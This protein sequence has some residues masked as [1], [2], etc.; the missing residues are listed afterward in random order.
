MSVQVTRAVL[1]EF[2]TGAETNVL[3]LT[4]G[5][6]TGKT[7]AWREALIA[8]RKEIKFKNYCYISL[9]GINTMAELRMALFTKS[10]AVATL[11]ENIDFATIK[12]HWGSMTKDWMK[13]QYDRFAPLFKSL[14]HGSSISLGL[15]AL[16]PSMVRD[17]LICFDDFERQTTI[18]AEDVLGLITELREERGC[19]I[20]LIFNAEKL[21]AKDAYRA[22]REKAIDFE[23]L[24][25]PTVQEAFDLVF[26]ASFPSREVVLRHVFDLG[27]T[28]VRILRKLRQV[29]AR[30]QGVTVGMHTDV[31]E[32]SIA[33]SVLLCWCTYEPDPSKPQL[34][35]IENWNRYLF[36]WKKDAEE[37]PATLAWTK[38]LKAYGFVHV[39][40]LDL[41]IARIVERGYVEGTG[42]V[43]AARKIDSELRS[44]DVSAPFSAAWHRFHDSFSG[45]QEE[46]VNGLFQ[47]TVQA[48]SHIGGG[49]LNAT[50]QLLREL[51]RNDLADDLIEKFVVANKGRPSIFDLKEHPFGGSI[52]D[53]KLRESFEAVHS[54]LATLPSLEE[55]VIFM[56]RHSGYN[57]E[58]LDAM[59]RASVDDYEAMFLKTHADVRL[60]SLIKWSLRWEGTEHAQITAKAR[61][62]LQRIK[63]INLLNKVRVARYGV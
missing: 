1:K 26:E 9:F 56:A 14:P 25:S 51:N 61:E 18:N 46:F 36:S 3:A 24:Y 7:Y 44:K 41:S 30:I 54:E 55:S 32:T 50:V 60:S 15:E 42:F 4:G 27:I 16:A 19:K 58:H 43:E 57:R 45:E 39:D 52:D 2:L 5:W 62:A 29:I 11:D 20:A 28:N 53:E 33:T 10:I 31:F 21:R 40:D 59:E 47:A 12:D 63:E 17:T 48:I 13:R 22:Y 8:H 34:E 37:D 23:V 38:R 6:G 35:D 49:D